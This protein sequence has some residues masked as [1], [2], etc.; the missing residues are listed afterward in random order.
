M[1]FLGR[2]VRF[3]QPYRWIAVILV[4]TVIFPVVMELVVPR[5][6]QYIVDQGIRAGNMKVITQ[7]VVIMLGAALIGALATLGQGVCRARL[8]QGMAFDMR[9]E[10]F[11]HIQTFSFANLDRLQTGQLMTRLSSDVDVVRMFASSGLS[12]MLR[13]L[14]MIIGSVA[15]LVLTDRQLSLVILIL[16]PIA[17][18][19]IWGVM[20]IA[21]PLFTIVQQKLASLNTVVQENLAGAQVV[22]TF[23]REKFEIGRFDEYNA[24]YMH[25]NI[26]VGRLMAVAL[27][28]LTVLTNL[29]IVAIIWRGGMDVIG[30]RLS[31]G[32]LI[33]FNNYLMIGMTPLLLLS[34]M[35]TMVSRAEASAE[36]VLQVLDT[37]PVLHTQS[38]PCKAEYPMGSVVFE[39]VSFHYDGN[40]GEKVLSRVSLSVEPGQRVALLG[41]T[42]SGKSTLMN[43]IPRFYDATGGH[44]RIDGI[45]VRDWST[46]A[47]RSQIG[48]VLQQTTLFSGTIRENIAFGR[49]DAPLEKVVA[50]AKAAQVHEFIITMPKGYDSIVEARGANLSGGQRQRIAI[51]RA[52]LISPRILILDDS[53]SAV[54]VET[55]AK[56]QETLEALMVGRTTFIVAQRISSV[57]TADQIIVLDSGRFAAQGTHLQLLDTSPIYQ[58]IYRSQLGVNTKD[59]KR[60]D[61]SKNR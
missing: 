11:A 2:V 37:E 41:T 7:R 18:A 36:R 42:G 48:V 53:T 40:G 39:N 26:K 51:A 23:V 24:A 35:L 15:M 43:L 44:V 10:L 30:G 3:V 33:A 49:P 45:D 25:Q 14:M 31:V 21:R 27:P 17:A 60:Y 46:D 55:E 12:L 28:A 19:V 57:L 32:E 34:N 16:L 8:S 5:M 54:D 38:S 6:L 47:L 61:K 22:K 59:A 4:F 58:E 20:Q 9:N 56:I 52:L 13:A 1:K 50:A 29:G